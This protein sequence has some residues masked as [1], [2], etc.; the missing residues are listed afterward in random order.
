MESSLSATS[1]AR[2]RL[3]QLK[4]QL[5]N[6]LKRAEISYQISRNSASDFR[7][8]SEYN[9]KIFDV[10]KKEGELVTPQTPLAV[11]GRT[12]AFMMELQV[13]ENDIALIQEGQAADLTL[14]AFPGQVFTA[15][16]ERIIPI[17][18]ERTRNFKV[19]AGF[20]QAPPSLYPNI[21][22]EANIIIKKKENALVI[23]RSY[24]LDGNF[25]LVSKKEKRAVTIGLK[26]F[27]KVEILSGIDS[28]T[29]I[30]MPEK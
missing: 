16:L 15:K 9:G 7:V 29:T 2:K 10:L 30:Y 20:I 13:N 14:E 28:S 24:L 17:M 27:Q 5:Q 1:T 26:D 18:N 22:V 6:E 4:T 3:D 8:T 25:V 23:P 21:N 11:I 19:E 12:D